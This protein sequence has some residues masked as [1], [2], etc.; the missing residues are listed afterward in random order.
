VE[1]AFRPALIR[2]YFCHPEPRELSFA[3]ASASRGIS[4]LETANQQI[5][6]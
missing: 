5:S 3:E 4:V 2:P 6:N 1:Q